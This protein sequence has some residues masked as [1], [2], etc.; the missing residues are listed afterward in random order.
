M[1]D[2]RTYDDPHGAPGSGAGR[3]LTDLPPPSGNPA[4]P[5]PGAFPP[6]PDSPFPQPDP[7]GGGGRD[8]WRAL[9]G[10][11]PTAVLALVMLLVPLYRSGVFE[12]SFNTPKLVLLVALCLV[13][14]I[15]FLVRGCGRRVA[16]TRWYP[17]AGAL[18]ALVLWLGGSVLWAWSKPL[19]VDGL[20]YFSLFMI[21]FWLLYRVPISL[22]AL[23]GLFAAG[24]MAAVATAVWVL[25]DDVS[26][27]GGRTVA[28]LPDWRGYLSAGLGNSGHIAGMVG[29]FL[30]WVVLRFLGGRGRGNWL[31]LAV[32][33]VMFAALVVT[34]SVG[35]T[36]ATV[37][38][39]CVWALVAWRVLR[40]GVL[41]W[42]RLAG[43]V[44]VGL[45]VSA[46][47]LLPHGLNPHERG[48]WNEAFGSAR[49]EAGWPTRI[50][51][52]LTTWQM[53][54]ADP[55]LGIGAGNFTY[56]YTQQVVDRVVSDPTLRMYSGAFTNDAHNDFLH[57]WCE[58][59]VVALVAWLG[60]I[61][62]FFS[63]VWREL[64]RHAARPD[65]QALLIAAGAGF[66]IFLLDGLMSFPM[67]LPAHFAMAVFF[68]AVPGVVGRLRSDRGD[69]LLPE[70]EARIHRRRL[71]LGGVGVV[72]TLA[73]CCWHLG[74]RVVAEYY[75][76][77]GRTA[78]DSGVVMLTGGQMAGVWSLCDEQYRWVLGSIAQG[79]DEDAWRAGLTRM[80][81]L[82]AGP[83]MEDALENFRR[84]NDAD[85]WYAN[86]SSRL[87][88]LLLFRGDYAGALETGRRTLKTLEAYEI[89]ER[90][91]AAAFFLGDYK[92]ARE[93]WALCMT[94]RP[95]SAEF[96]RALLGRLPE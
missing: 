18:L 73:A 87:G 24:A 12:D 38:G 31:W 49:W 61:G 41:H 85:R 94:R 82:S 14:S 76:K 72:L 88:Q 95:E 11:L 43:V 42:R 30:P 19:G 4:D 92:R 28:R 57:L 7:L 71:R 36:G 25:Y 51:I 66:T 32:L 83:A 78:A 79:A 89:H 9:T 52:W 58:G 37:L 62:L 40:P 45:L 90:M 80:N 23:R 68:L 8:A 54:A 63:A 56:G 93:H 96:Y 70:R 29:M 5:A 39:L 44:G 21:L 27:G 2:S 47:Y 69:D 1:N 55:L 86:A 77:A 6:Q 74:H 50:V 33:G 67:R 59:G 26:Q 15:G 60:V 84:S 53:I 75:L 64:R 16:R 3:N 81:A 13:A 91:G 46:F 48:L 10:D 65:V 34:W 35:S 22:A 20:V 17:V